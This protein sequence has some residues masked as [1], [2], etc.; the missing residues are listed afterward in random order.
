LKVDGE[1]VQSAFL[2][3]LFS[4]MVALFRFG[5]GGGLEALR[6]QGRRKKERKKEP[7]ALLDGAYVGYALQQLTCAP[8][9]M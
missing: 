5:C 1:R 6:V 2:F 3:W 9:G 8:G 4:L 7:V